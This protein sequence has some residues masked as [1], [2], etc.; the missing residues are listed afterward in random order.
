MSKQSLQEYINSIQ[1]SYETAR[2]IHGKRFSKEAEDFDRSEKEAQQPTLSAQRNLPSIMHKDMNRE[3]EVSFIS[4]KHLGNGS[5]GDVDEVQELTTGAIYARKHIHLDKEKP[6]EVIKEEVKNEVAIMQ[7]LRHRHIASVLFYVKKA[8]SYSIFM[9]PVA[10]WDLR[11][12]FDHCE[13]KEFEENLIKCI[14][15]WF[16]CLLDALAYAHKEEIKHQDIKP[17]NVLIKNN[18]PYLSDFGLAKSFEGMGDSSSQVVKRHGTP[19]YFAPEVVMGKKRGRS[20]DIFSLGC[21]FTEMFTVTQKKSTKDYYKERNKGREPSK[22]SNQIHF[23]DC[24]PTVKTW[25]EQFGES[26]STKS[27]LRAIKDMIEED[28]LERPKAHFI[29]KGLKGQRQFFCVESD[30]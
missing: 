16:G 18:Q 28:P 19:V 5:F 2:G 3:L 20:A 11:K 13:E 7:K 1:Q 22:G 8:D 17:S 9:L 26:R 24:L 4:Q 15:P 25:M 12:Y 30:V 10:D 6:A 14:N 21:V 23:R 29:L 27:L